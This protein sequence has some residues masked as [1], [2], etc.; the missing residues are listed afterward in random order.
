MLQL[1][2]P[3]MVLYTSASLQEPFPSY[4]NTRT[5]T[6]TKYIHR[7]NNKIL[8]KNLSHRCGVTSVLY[9]LSSPLLCSSIRYCSSGTSSFVFTL[10]VFIFISR[11]RHPSTNNWSAQLRTCPS[12]S[13]SHRTLVASH[14]LYLLCC[15]HEWLRLTQQSRVIIW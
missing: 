5:Y 14:V 15:L 4:T 12:S 10:L 13:H 1:N 2:R 8:S 11:R 6:R 9:R 3:C 7:C